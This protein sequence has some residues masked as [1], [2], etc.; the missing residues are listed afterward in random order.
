MD[1]PQIWLESV[2]GLWAIAAIIFTGVVSW[3]GSALNA[4][5]VQKKEEK[6]YR[7]DQA[8]KHDS[9]EA[10]VDKLIDI[11]SEFS[12]EQNKKLNRI[13]AGLELC[14]EN[15]EIVFGAFRK[16]KILNGESEAQSKKLENFRQSLMHDSLAV[17]TILEELDEINDGPDD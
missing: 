14:M 9:L 11:L 2:K 12:K 4:R 5:R 15:D 16:T 3:I 7:E 6:Q 1:N 10:K 17:S 13:S 8:R